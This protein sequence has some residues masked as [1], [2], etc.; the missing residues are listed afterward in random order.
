[1]CLIVLNSKS[2]KIPVRVFIGSGGL[3]VLLHYDRK[4]PSMMC[5]VSQVCDFFFQKMIFDVEL[6]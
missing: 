6:C 5:G 3:L 1:M 2:S 4:V